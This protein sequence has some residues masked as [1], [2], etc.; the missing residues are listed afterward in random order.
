LKVIADGVGAFDEW[1]FSQASHLFLCAFIITIPV[2]VTNSTVELQ[3]AKRIL[4]QFP[5]DRSSDLKSDRFALE[6]SDEAITLAQQLAIEDYARDHPSEIKVKRRGPLREM[7]VRL[8]EGV[9]VQ[10]GS[11]VMSAAATTITTT[12]TTTTTK[13]PTTAE[14]VILEIDLLK[15]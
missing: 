6:A 10:V 1:T 5:R 7:L 3:K 9:G 11:S 13:L 4:E 14:E 2:A 12:T 15:S 8:K